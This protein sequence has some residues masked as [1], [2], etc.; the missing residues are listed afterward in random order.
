SAPALRARPERPVPPE[1]ARR[2]AAVGHHELVCQQEPYAGVGRRG[3]MRA[4][5]P[6]PSPPNILGGPGPP[7]ARVP[8]PGGPANGARGEG[9]PPDALDRRHRGDPLRRA[10]RP[11]RV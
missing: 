2:L 10:F 6:R 11:D 1:R 4:R 5:L 8:S 9:T 3:G 7:A